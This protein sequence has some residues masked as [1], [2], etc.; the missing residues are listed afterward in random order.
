MKIA[1]KIKYIIAHDQDVARRRAQ[2][3]SLFYFH[4]KHPQ[5][6][7]FRIHGGFCSTTVDLMLKD[8]FSDHSIGNVWMM[9]LS[10]YP[11]YSDK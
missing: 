11:N 1:D 5:K 2:L 7:Y 10:S 9:P 4:Q 8:S 3:R 6:C